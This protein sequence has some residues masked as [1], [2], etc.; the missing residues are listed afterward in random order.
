MLKDNP[1]PDGYATTA[2]LQPDKIRTCAMAFERRAT[3]RFLA[4]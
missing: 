1:A 4:V 3:M 2:M